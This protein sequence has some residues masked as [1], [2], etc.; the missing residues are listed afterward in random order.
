V[1]ADEPGLAVDEFTGGVQVTGVGGG[2]GDHVQQDQPQ[3]AQVKAPSWPP[4]A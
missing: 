2:L 1:L 4:G 3:V